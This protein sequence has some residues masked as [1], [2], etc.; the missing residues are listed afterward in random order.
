MCNKF[1]YELV[2]LDPH[3]HMPC[4]PAAL[5]PRRTVVECIEPVSVADRPGPRS[6][7]PIRDCYY[8]DFVN[9]ATRISGRV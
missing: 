2:L 3:T 1:K 7:S 6:E 8:A 4:Y 9:L 5:D